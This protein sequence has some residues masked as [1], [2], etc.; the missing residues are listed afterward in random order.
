M[1]Y[2]YIEGTGLDIKVNTSNIS[3]SQASSHEFIGVSQL[4]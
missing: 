4:K 2:C 3:Q 1:E